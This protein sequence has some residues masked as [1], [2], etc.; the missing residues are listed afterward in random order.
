MKL[1]NSQ[2]KNAKVF[3][4]TH[5]QH[6]DVTAFWRMWFTF[7]VLTERDV[8]V[9]AKATTS[10]RT[11]LELLP[12]RR[13]F[14][15]PPL[16]KPPLNYSHFSPNSVIHVIV[17]FFLNPF[18]AWVYVTQWMMIQP[19]SCQTNNK[20]QTYRS[21]HWYMY[22][23]PY[24]YKNLH[25]QKKNKD[26]RGKPSTSSHHRKKNFQHL[27]VQ[28]HLYVKLVKLHTNTC[29]TKVHCNI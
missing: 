17:K 27:A 12:R 22:L 19:T 15:H 9:E 4:R 3:C 25:A 28:H 5:T 29:I 2:V 14:I 24:L 11:V 1:Y 23:I 20:Q 7:E 18:W 26:R 16:V 10:L 6:H 13:T 21:V 8:K